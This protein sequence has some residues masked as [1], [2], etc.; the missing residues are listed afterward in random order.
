MIDPIDPRDIP[1]ESRDIQVYLD[2]LTTH[3]GPDAATHCLDCPSKDD[4]QIVWMRYSWGP[5]RH[6]G[7]RLLCPPC[8][9]KDI[10]DLRA[11]PDWGE[12]KAFATTPV[13]VS[14]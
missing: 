1:F 2:A 5:E 9:E 3:M 12:P 8:A 13:P 4:L 10:A 14:A 11:R 7:M 6:A